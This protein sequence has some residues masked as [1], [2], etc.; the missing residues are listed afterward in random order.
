MRCDLT[1]WLSDDRPV[2][3]KRLRVPPLRSPDGTCTGL[4]IVCRSTRDGLVFRFEQ[5]KGKGS[6]GQLYVG[7]RATTIKRS[8]LS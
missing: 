4:P 2:L 6:H 8:E 1:G 5:G 3:A 7:G